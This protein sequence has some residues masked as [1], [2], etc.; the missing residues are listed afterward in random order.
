[1][2]LR[3]PNRDERV[4]LTGK[5]AR[6][7]AF[8]SGAIAS[9]PPGF[10]V[11]LEGPEDALRRWTAACEELIAVASSESMPPRPRTASQPVLASPGLGGKEV[12]LAIPATVSIESVVAPLPHA[13]QAAVV[14]GSDVGE[15]LA[16]TLDEQ[17]LAQVGTRPVM[18]DPDTMGVREERPSE[19]AMNTSELLGGS[20]PPLEPNI[21]SPPVPMPSAP[22]AAAA[23]AQEPVFDRETLG[24]MRT[25]LLH[26][27]AGVEAPHP[28][29]A[30]EE[31]AEAKPR[32]PEPR[33]PEPPPPPSARSTD[34]ESD[35]KTAVRASQP[36][37]DAPPVPVVPLADATIPDAPLTTLDPEPI[38]LT[39]TKALP[40]AAT[41][42]SAMASPYAPAA[43]PAG[44]PN[45]EPAPTAPPAAARKP[46]AT[47]SVQQTLPMGIPKQSVSESA[48]QAAPVAAATQRSAAPPV[49][50]RSKSKRPSSSHPPPAEPGSKRAIWISLA[51]LLA[52]GTGM[53]LALISR[54]NERAAP[55][56]ASAQA[57]PESPPAP[58]VSTATTPTATVT[59]T[60]EATAP[61]APAAS[62]EPAPSAT[63]TSTIAPGPAPSADLT[64][65]P[66]D[67][68]YLLVHSS[69]STHVFV[70]GTDYGPTNQ[71]LMT[72]CGIR[73]V[74]LGGPLG[75]FIE[76]GESKVIKC[77]RFTELTIEPR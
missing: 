52:A 18:I 25:V 9:A 29:A 46:L 10:S 48:P 1:V 51:L 50:A 67:R 54:Q 6:R 76:P 61:A 16:A 3:L 70:H 73:F 58:A 27:G 5:V 47:P 20:I 33:D 59:A 65:L 63:A 35:A 14:E 44:N 15:L 55:H 56:A 71:V 34:W 19:F 57:V 68:A 13:V 72:S 53:A 8:G 40:L 64:K 23:P 12:P 7:F 21:S 77:G 37:I 66:A 69:V 31:S 28:V 11:K 45:H 36:A 75:D 74:R 41:L 2:E 26:P 17:T 4:R 22:T 39:P 32:D 43:P 42:P 30:P 49:A 24:R 62:V 38:P 60:T